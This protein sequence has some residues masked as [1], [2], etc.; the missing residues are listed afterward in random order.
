[1]KLKDIFRKSKNKSGIIK[2]I[3]NRGYLL[4]NLLFY[5][6]TYPNIEKTIKLYLCNNEI[7]KLNIQ[8]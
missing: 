6:N 8:F 3:I 1:M 2:N 7:I 5:I 4:E